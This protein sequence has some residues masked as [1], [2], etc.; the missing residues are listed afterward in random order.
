MSPSKTKVQ[1]VFRPHNARLPNS[2]GSVPPSQR[3]TSQQSRK[4]S[5]TSHNKR[6]HR[7]SPWSTTLLWYSRPVKANVTWSFQ[8]TSPCVCIP[9][10]HV[11]GRRSDSMRMSAY[12]SS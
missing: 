2:P 4:S 11:P 7:F 12:V 6:R 10:V 9:V 8:K 1:E 5:N 3:E